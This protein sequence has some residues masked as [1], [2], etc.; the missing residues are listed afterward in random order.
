MK[1]DENVYKKCMADILIM[2][3]LAKSGHPGGS[4]STLPLLF[5]AKSI[6]N[7]VF[8]SNGHV[9]PAVYAY[10]Y[11]VEKKFAKNEIFMKYRNFLLDGHVT[12]NTKTGIPWSTG[13]L[14][15]GLS[16]ACAQALYNIRSGIQEK[17][18]C[19]VGDGEFQKGQIIEAF[20]FAKKYNLSNLVVLV[21]YNN[22]QITGNLIIPPL[23]LT[24]DGFR[25]DQIKY[26]GN[27]K[28]Y[29]SDIVKVISDD[30]ILATSPHIVYCAAPMGLYI[31]HI[32]DNEEY[33]GKPVDNKLLNEII[34]WLYGKKKYKQIIQKINQLRN[35]RGA[36]VPDIIPS[37]KR[38][39]KEEFRKNV[40]K[41]FKK[42]NLYKKYSEPNPDLRKA[43]NQ[44]LYSYIIKH[45]DKQYYIFD[46]DLA[47]SVGLAK[48]SKS[49]AKHV[50]FIE[51][52]ITE[53]HTC[54]MA[55]MM[56]TLPNVVSIWSDFG[57]FGLDEVYNQLRMIN[58]TPGTNLK[59]FLT[60][61]GVN[62]GEDGKTHHCIDYLN[63]CAGLTNFQTVI[64]PDSYSLRNIVRYVLENDG[65]YIVIIPRS[66]APQVNPDKIEYMSGFTR[67]R[68]KDIVSAVVFTTSHTYPE[69][70]YAQEYLL[71]TLNIP[72]DVCCIFDPFFNWSK[73]DVERYEFSAC[74]LVQ[75]HLNNNIMENNLRKVIPKLHV[76]GLE[77]V[78]LS[79]SKNDLY[80]YHG[81]SSNKIAN[82]ITN[83][84]VKG[85]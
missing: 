7:Y 31:P 21:D 79:A 64:P 2:T 26:N 28:D 23:K 22:K 8:V 61:T 65:N 29:I 10:A 72:I 11:R 39:V 20:R 67:V 37:K 1:F 30:N 73:Y 18:V 58:L 13:S 76:I 41:Y 12:K 83:L 49:K 33:H 24:S 77:D 35:K 14:G 53:H 38:N 3:N 78:S 57:N 68:A 44:Y 40:Y 19:I 59:L 60:H 63:L 36:Y 5:A 82:K 48:I 50:H 4:L 46:C 66:S 15:Q 80:N 34:M 71:N 70:L 17:V 9:S 74:I 69:T 62:V 81:F 52:G 47:P 55:G 84:I 32:I 51:C 56:S 54:T 45:K 25:V 6:S 75:D 27:V 85:V 42:F 16:A 43:L